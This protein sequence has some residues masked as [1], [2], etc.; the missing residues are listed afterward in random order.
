LASKPIHRNMADAKAKRLSVGLAGVQLLAGFQRVVREFVVAS[1]NINCDNSAM[2]AF[3]GLMANLGFKK[4]G[5][6]AGE[7]FF[8]VSRLSWQHVGASGA[9]PWRHA[10]DVNELGRY[11]KI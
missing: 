10:A 11:E 5:A 9:A 7:L 3:F 6:P 4:L 2:I 8:A 1:L